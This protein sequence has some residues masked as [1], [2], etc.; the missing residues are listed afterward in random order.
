M[1][2]TTRARL[3]LCRLLSDA[4]LWPAA[5]AFARFRDEPSW[6][7]GDPHPL[8]DSVGSDALVDSWLTWCKSRRSAKQPPLG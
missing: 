5:V 8:L 4:V 2:S 1:R 7:H 3:A 6:P